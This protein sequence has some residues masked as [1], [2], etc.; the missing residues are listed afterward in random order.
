MT[1]RPLIIGHR[2]AS[3][4]A[5]ENT[6]AAFR[7]ALDEGADGVEFDVRLTRDGIPVVIHDDNLRRT[8]SLQLRVADLTFADLRKI[9]VGSW[10]VRR[11]RHSGADFVGECIPSLQQL[12]DLFTNNQSLLYLELKSDESKR[13]ELT[14]ACCRLL[15]T[16][17][18]RERV[19]VESFDLGGIA[20]V[21]KLEPKI[22]T[23][24]LF[25]PSIATPPFLQSGQRIVDEATAVGASEIALHYKLVNDRVM[26]NAK[27]AGLNVIVWTVD[28]PRWVWRAKSMGIH[29][30]ITND[31]GKM[32]QQRNQPAVD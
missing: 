6:M 11:R 9:D 22:R 8:G 21:K 12:L 13:Q 20:A 29:A 7:L 24:A 4:L 19:V 5:P 17:S 16:H 30:L 26:E 10:F 18:V 23:A 28:E 3:A 27:R 2:G 25:E 1:I 15:S 32:L 31:P 14:V